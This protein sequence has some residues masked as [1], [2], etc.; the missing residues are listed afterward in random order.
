[1]TNQVETLTN[2]INEMQEK[3]NYYEELLQD[4]GFDGYKLNF[5]SD[6]KLY[7]I[8]FVKE[9]TNLDELVTNPVK[10]GFEFLGWSTDDN[11]ENIIDLNTLKINKD[12]NLYA[13]FKDLREWHTLLNDNGN[14][15]Y[16]SGNSGNQIKLSVEGLTTDSIFKVNFAGFG[17]TLT[18]FMKTETF[19]FINS[20]EG[21][22][23]KNHNGIPYS[24]D[25]EFSL[26]KNQYIEANDGSNYSFTV[27]CVKNNELII[28]FNFNTSVSAFCFLSRIYINDIQVLY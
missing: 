8:C 28:T 7:L 15:N 10:N 21:V 14:T 24:E 2:Q 27:N 1:M 20:E 16:V 19:Y 6:N 4:A 25:F 3:I 23:I 5:F 26:G 11:E 18:N 9:N 22:S 12:T 17:F 13:I